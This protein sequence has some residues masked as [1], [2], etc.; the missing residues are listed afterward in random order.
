VSAELKLSIFSGMVSLEG[1][2][3]YLSDK[4]ESHKPVSPALVYHITT[5]FQRL[6]LNNLNTEFI[7]HDSLG[8]KDATHVVTGIKWGANA[9]VTFEHA[10]DENSDKEEVSGKL[11]AAFEKVK[12]NVSGSAQGSFTE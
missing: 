7:C 9:N 2:G 11:R 3:K 1:S 4:K 10:N 12:I 5:K 8:L 6:V